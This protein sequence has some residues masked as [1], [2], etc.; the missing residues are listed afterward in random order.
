MTRTPI[1]EAAAETLATLQK[2]LVERGANYAD[3]ADN[4]KVFCDLLSSMGFTWPKTMTD[5]QVHCVCNIATKLSRL[6]TGD[7]QHLDSL[8]D[9]GGYA[10]LVHADTARNQQKV[11]T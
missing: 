10:V 9:L 1:T 6:K 8:L 3:I 4:S 5:T 2:T 7:F 11:T